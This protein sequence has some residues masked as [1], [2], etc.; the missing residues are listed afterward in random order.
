[1]VSNI[2]ITIFKNLCACKKTNHPYNQHLLKHI[3]LGLML[4]A[5]SSWVMLPIQGSAFENGVMFCIG[6]RFP[7]VWLRRTQNSNFVEW[8]TAVLH[9]LPVPHNSP[10][11]QLLFQ[12]Y[13]VS[14]DLVV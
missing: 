1:M 10:D 12:V 8:F 14:K 7:L 11:A 2:T 3:G 13:H 6:I 5:S 4:T 9:W